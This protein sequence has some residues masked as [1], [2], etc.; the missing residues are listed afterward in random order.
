MS[1][2]LRKDYDQLGSVSYWP[3]ILFVRLLLARSK[4]L[5]EVGCF[6]MMIVELRCDGLHPLYYPLVVWKIVPTFA[7]LYSL[8]WH[9]GRMT[10]WYVSR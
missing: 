6:V 9:D 4:E 8:R 10:E 3:R 5:T 2:R 1:Y 7:S